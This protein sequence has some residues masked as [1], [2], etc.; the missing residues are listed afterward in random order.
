[1]AV[2]FILGSSNSYVE[3]KSYYTNKLKQ[4]PDCLEMAYLEAR[5]YKPTRAA[6]HSLAAIE[7]ANALAMTRRGGKGG[8]GG[9]PGGHNGKSAPNAKWVKDEADSPREARM[10]RLQLRDIR[11]DRATTAVITNIWRMSAKENQPTLSSSTGRIRDRDPLGV[12]P[13]HHLDLGM[14][15]E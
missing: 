7:R 11:E 14:E 8:R 13:T 5:K 3:F 2:K 4:W 1:M 6:D 9:Y 12:S 15:S 10:R